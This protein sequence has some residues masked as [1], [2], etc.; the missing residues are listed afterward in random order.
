MELDWREKFTGTD[1]FIMNNLFVV[2][3]VVKLHRIVEVA[4]LLRGAVC[5]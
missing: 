2:L 4:F 5:L 3:S 1:M